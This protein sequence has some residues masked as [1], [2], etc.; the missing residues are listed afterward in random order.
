M[1]NKKFIIK[2][3]HGYYKDFFTPKEMFTQDLEEAERFDTSDKAHGILSGLKVFGHTKTAEIIPVPY[4]PAAGDDFEHLLRL[5]AQVVEEAEENAAANPTSAE[6]QVVIVEPMKKPYKKVIP[7]NLD[8]MK[9]IV[10]GWIENVTIDKTATGA[11]VSIVVNEEGK[12]IGL[13]YN[14]RIIG[15]GGSDILVGPFFITAY[16]LEGDNVSLS[17]DDAD[18]L[19]RRFAAME[20]YL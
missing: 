19:V 4:E 14:R 8:A 15:R 2:T 7:N 13:P 10:G 11:R 16:N 18:R 1:R 17:D 3:E 12:L 5:A 6:I 9:E 20:V